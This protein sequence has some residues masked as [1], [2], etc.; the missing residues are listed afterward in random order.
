MMNMILDF[1]T[2]L[3]SLGDV[4]DVIL[5]NVTHLEYCYLTHKS[6]ISTSRKERP[7]QAKSNTEVTTI[8][9]AVHS[10]SLHLQ[11]AHQR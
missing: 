5:T 11:A 1:F 4:N 10:L 7:F 3:R 6:Q 8:Y 9:T 2:A